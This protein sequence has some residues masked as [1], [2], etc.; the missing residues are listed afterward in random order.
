M[1]GGGP[2]DAG[3][4]RGDAA[5]I[6]GVTTAT[7]VGTSRRPLLD[8]QAVGASVIDGIRLLAAHQAAATKQEKT[9]AARQDAAD[10]RESLLAAQRAEL[11]ARAERL[12]VRET[13]MAQREVDLAAA[14]AELD[15][16]RTRARELARRERENCKMLEEILRRQQ[17]RL[18]ELSFSREDFKPPWSGRWATSRWPSTATPIS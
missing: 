10:K 2:S 11:L 8:L 17:G 7:S 14:T 9:L 18:M 13:A 12:A 3:D 1:V 6:E 16:A 15:T 4:S 5:S